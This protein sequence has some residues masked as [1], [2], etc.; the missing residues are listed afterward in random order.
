MGVSGVGIYREHAIRHMITMFK[1]LFYCFV[2]TFSLD[3]FHLYPAKPE[4]GIV[5]TTKRRYRHQLLIAALRPSRRWT[6]AFDP[7]IAM[8]RSIHADILFVCVNTCDSTC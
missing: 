6:A 3:I 8:R 5:Q 7:D 2:I 4:T 1:I